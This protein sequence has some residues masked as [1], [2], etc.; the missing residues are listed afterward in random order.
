VAVLCPSITGGLLL[1]LLQPDM[2]VLPGVYR[3]LPRAQLWRL[4]ELDI[5]DVDVTG[6]PGLSPPGRTGLLHL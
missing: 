1:R 4:S 2:P 5:K 3:L 6:R